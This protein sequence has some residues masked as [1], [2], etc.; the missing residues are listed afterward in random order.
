M[1]V[2]SFRASTIKFLGIICVAITALITIIAFV[3]TYTANPATDAAAESEEVSYSYD[4]VRDVEDVKK[5]LSQFGF[6]VAKDAVEVTE[7]TLPEQFD[8]VMNDYNEIQKRQGLDLTRYKGKKLTR[9]TMEITNY[10][11]YKGTVYANVI[12]YKNKVV[13]GD[14]CSADV[15][16][17]IKT[18]ENK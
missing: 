13:A 2:Y 18:F 4:K 7:V 5:F 1:F 17:F 14:V 16:G 11:G 8:G 9:Y 6:A 3:P 15:N 12:T 10:E